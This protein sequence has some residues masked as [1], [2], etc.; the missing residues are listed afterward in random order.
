MVLFRLVTTAYPRK[1]VPFGGLVE[2]QKCGPPLSLRDLRPELPDSFVSV[3]E[4]SLARDP[5]ERPQTAGS[6]QAALGVVLG[7]PL[8]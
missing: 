6:L 1:V 3:V 2:P 7:V 5:S 8:S 4:R